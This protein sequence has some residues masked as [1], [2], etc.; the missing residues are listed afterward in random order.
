MKLTQAH[1]LTR[2]FAVARRSMAETWIEQGKYPYPYEREVE[3][4]LVDHIQHFLI[5]LGSGFAFGDAKCISS[6]R[7]ATNTSTYSSTTR[8]CVVMS[9]SS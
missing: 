5:E 2:A 6:S 3:Q 1:R 4:A 8:S 9:S 7:A